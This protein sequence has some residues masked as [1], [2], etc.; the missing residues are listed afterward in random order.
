[1]K[2]NNDWGLVESG[3]VTSVGKETFFS[4][5]TVLPLCILLQCSSGEKYHEKQTNKQTVCL[6]KPGE[7]TN[8]VME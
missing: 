7:A 6:T 4:P 3:R 8:D 5:V 2:Q 1:M